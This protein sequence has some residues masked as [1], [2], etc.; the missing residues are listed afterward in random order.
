MARRT[1]IPS[2]F[3]LFS[4]MAGGTFVLWETKARS[5]PPLAGRIVAAV[6]VGVQGIPHGFRL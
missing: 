1:W 3:C 6:R 5:L 2:I 4:D